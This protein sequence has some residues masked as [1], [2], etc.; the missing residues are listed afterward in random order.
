[1]GDKNGIARNLS[2]I[3][4]VNEDQKNYHKALEYYLQALKISKELGLKIGIAMNLGSIGST[5]LE[6]AK[7]SSTGKHNLAALQKAKFYTDTAIIICKEISDLNTLFAN[8][9][10]LS[11]IQ[12]LLGDNRS[13][14][15]S[16]KNYTL[17][18]D[19]V[20]NMEK[21]KK[22]TETAMQYAFDKKEA[23]A[24]TKQEKKDI[25]QRNIRNWFIAG[26]AVL[27]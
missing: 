26:S 16:Y 6:M 13:A 7:D 14:L 4:I 11:E 23:A 12:A 17:I 21:D 18:K 25:R 20:F 3:G 24:R 27:L 15:E 1:L 8:Y 5:Y 19:S 2:N 10:R 22:L 9:K